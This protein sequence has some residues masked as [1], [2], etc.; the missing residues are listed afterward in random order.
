MK[1][2]RLS[3]SLKL[4]V[5]SLLAAV[6]LTGNPVA[7]GEP[8][9]DA[10]QQARELLSGRS[11]VTTAHDIPMAPAAV[12]PTFG[13]AQSHARGVLAPNAEGRPRASSATTIRV[14]TGAS[15]NSLAR[16]Q[17]DAQQAARHV[18]GGQAA[19]N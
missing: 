19:L 10:Q 14:M 17:P 9:N 2:V 5:L 1:I 3:G 8:S 7:A 4:S 16:N 15:A 18:L 11:R 12:S 6:S 13:D